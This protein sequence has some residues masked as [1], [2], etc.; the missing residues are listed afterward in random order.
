MKRFLN[1]LMGIFRGVG[2]L[3]APLPDWQTHRTNIAIDTLATTTDGTAPSAI[4]ALTSYSSANN[5]SY[6]YD[7]TP[8]ISPYTARRITI[9]VQQTA[10]TAPAVDYTV[11]LAIYYWDYVNA[12]WSRDAFP[13]T[14][15][16]VAS[17]ALNFSITHQVSGLP[18]YVAI[19]NISTGASA[20]SKARID[21][22]LE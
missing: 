17:E 16:M 13:I 9:K 3:A 10:G 18:F 2:E 5:P 21:W 14:V 8:H 7:N 15:S 1:T 22:S 19:R 11:T 12:C 6:P 20:S 4:P